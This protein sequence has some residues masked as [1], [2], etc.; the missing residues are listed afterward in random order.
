MRPIKISL[1]GAGSRCFS[2]G[3]IQDLCQKP[4]L[5]GATVS[6]MDIDETRLQ[7]VETL[8]RRFA[9]EKGA[10]LSI[11]AT[12]DRRTSLKGAD[13]VVNTACP[14]A[15]HRMMEGMDIALRHRYRFNGS[16]HLLYDEA[17]WVNYE[18]LRFFESLTEDVLDVCPQA[19]HLLVANPV[20]A[21]STHLG[22]KYPT[23]RLVGICH[24]YAGVY[25]A[26]DALGLEGQEVTYQIPGTNHFVWLTEFRYRGED[27]FPLL[28]RWIDTEAEAYWA[29]C[30]N[31]SAEALSPKA[32]DLYRTFRA[33][34]IGDT[35]HWTGANWP[36]W[37]HSDAE[38]ME[39]WGEIDAYESWKRYA[40]GSPATAESMREVSED[41]SVEVSE[42]YAGES[43][44]SFVSLIESMACDIP[45]VF[46]GNNILN[47]GELVPGIGEDV[48]VEVPT[49]VSGRG[50][51]GIRTE[52]LPRGVLAWL[53][54][55]RVGPMEIELEAYQTGR[56]DLLLQLILMD[57]G[58][59]SR[60]QAAALLDEILALPYHKTMRAHYA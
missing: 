20:F 4:T 43:N 17:F 8:C 34:P 57:K 59:V 58:T 47:V 3:L 30:Q 51:Q 49:L 6:M 7:T 50:V 22:R 18:N 44:E 27:A 36:F 13:F 40:E 46:Q 1:I 37:Y 19:W 35:S 48:A 39:Q 56:R 9:A 54:R 29:S 2:V 16:Y 42:V 15:H 14:G 26:I 11:E 25:G 32:V 53:L 45:R 5:A 60:S 24:G 21:G 55:D 38:V 52:G 23:A 12:T 28:D 31:P 41:L 10:D 33:V